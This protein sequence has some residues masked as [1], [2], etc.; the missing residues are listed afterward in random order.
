MNIYKKLNQAR[1][2]LNKITLK[3]SG[4]NKFA[5][6]KYH[7]LSDFL[8]SIIEIN[9]KIGLTPIFS[10]M[11][12]YAVLTIIDNDKEDSKLEFKSQMV[13]LAVKGASAIQNIGAMQ[14]Y[15]RRYLYIMAY[16]ICDGDSVDSEDPKNVNAKKEDDKKVGKPELTPKSEKWLSVVSRYKELRSFELIEKHYTISDDNKKLL[17]IEAGNA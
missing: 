16:D 13:E 2:D 5:D 11:P 12:D 10:F 9:D 17:I 14:T 7:E 4:H 15:Q 6:F 3:K 1:S 8:P